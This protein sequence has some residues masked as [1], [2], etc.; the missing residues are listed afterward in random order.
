MGK[1]GFKNLKDFGSS[2]CRSC[3]TDCL[4]KLTSMILSSTKWSVQKFHILYNL[5]IISPI[6]PLANHSLHEVNFTN[7]FVTYNTY[8]KVSNNTHFKITCSLSFLLLLW[9]NPDTHFLQLTHV[10]RINVYLYM[11]YSIEFDQQNNAV[12]HYDLF[13]A[14]EKMYIVTLLL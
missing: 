9:R 3:Y 5:L 8:L 4:F 13:K 1:I 14:E 11:E 2:R 10:S 6:L 7:T 12:L